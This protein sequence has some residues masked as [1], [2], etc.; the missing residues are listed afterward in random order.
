MATEAEIYPSGLRLA[1]RLV[2]VVGGGSVAQRRIPRLLAA[3]AVVRVVLPHVTPAIEG[4]V[5]SGEITRVVVDTD[6]FMKRVTG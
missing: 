3:G 5:G 4:L 6:R 2:V 1:G